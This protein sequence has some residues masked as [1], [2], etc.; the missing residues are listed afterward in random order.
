MTMATLRNLKSIDYVARA[1]GVGTDLIRK[2]A[3]SADQQSYYEALKLSKKG[4]RRRGEYRVVFAARDEWLS[5]L[6]RGLAMVVTN[7]ANFGEHI[8]GFVKKRSTRSNAEK[9]LG[10][11]IILHADIKGFFDAITTQ[12]VQA[13]FVEHGASPHM[14]ETLAKACTIDGLLRQGTRCSPTVANLVCL[15]MD[16]AFLR[17]AA[18]TGCTYSRYADDIV[19]SGDS[20]PS[21]DS[22]RA[23]LTKS[24]FELRDGQCFH[25]RQGRV[26]Y[27]TGLSVADPLKPR[28]PRRLKNQLRLV[29]YYI[30]KYGLDDHLDKSSRSDGESSVWWLYGLLSY[31]QSIEPQLARKWQHVFSAAL[32]AREQNN[33]S[34]ATEEDWRL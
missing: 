30:E 4:K 14:A 16:E 2:Y 26:Q 1:C 29:M 3:E 12:H 11:K 33:S 18:S 5:Q 22:V 6:H 32:A 10:A 20:V 31:A 24:G 21:D 8:Q 19:F 13:A 28:L 17:L 9:H 25:Q 15:S 7:S 34:G 27:V 23:I